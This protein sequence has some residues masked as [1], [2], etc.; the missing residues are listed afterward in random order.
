MRRSSP[1]YS[2]LWGVNLDY[3]V[4]QIRQCCEVSRLKGFQPNWELSEI[5]WRNHRHLLT[6]SCKQVWESRGG[7]VKWDKELEHL[8][9]LLGQATETIAWDD[10]NGAE[11]IGRR[12]DLGSKR[13]LVAFSQ[14]KPGGFWGPVKIGKKIRVKEGSSRPTIAIVVVN[15]GRPESSS[16]CGLV[17]GS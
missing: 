10:A 6:R 7:Q 4:F 1:N 17:S 15:R 3:S 9:S 14:E 2:V 13:V 16:T 12:R 11:S 5:D 8:V